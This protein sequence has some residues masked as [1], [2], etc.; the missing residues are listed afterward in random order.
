MDYLTSIATFVR[1]AEVGSFVAVAEE[2]DLSPTMVGNHIRSLERRLGA[3]LIDRTTRRHDLTELGAAYL[4][5]CRDVL[6]SVAMA[7]GVGETLQSEPEGRLRVSASVSFGA[8]ALMPVITAYMATYPGVTIE[9]SLTDRLVDLAEEGIDVGFRSGRLIDETLVAR[10]LRQARMFAVASPAYIAQHG[11]PAE[12]RHIREEHCLGFSVW[13]RDH[14]WR[15]TRGDETVL[16]PV[17]G[18]LSCDNGQALLTAALCGVGVVVQ[19]D[20]LLSA[21]IASGE[22]IRLVPDWDLPTRPIHV[23]R[24]S[25]PRPSAKVRSFIDFAVGRLS[26]P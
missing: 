23:V 12:P 13:G 5:R 21:A 17:R 16:V 20:V 9:L 22:L 26:N 8:H 7:D 15:F 1:V 2:L 3:R 19:A 25:G 11:L 6:L 24:R 14:A 10:P 18:R 4:E